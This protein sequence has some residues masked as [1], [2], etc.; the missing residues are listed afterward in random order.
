MTNEEK[1]CANAEMVVQ[2][3][4]EQGLAYDQRS[5]DWIDGYIERNREGWDADTADKLGNMLGSFFGECIRQN[6]GGEW[7]MT[8]NGLAIEFSDGNAAF[9]FNKVNKHI[10]NG[11]GDSIASMYSSIAVLFQL[12]DA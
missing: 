10:A 11:D 7:K 12:N 2:T 1:I 3:F 5:V 8:D 4:T 6:F 9:P